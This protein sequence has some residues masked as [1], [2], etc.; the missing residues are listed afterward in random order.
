MLSRVSLLAVRRFSTKKPITPGWMQQAELDAA[1]A[2]KSKASVGTPGSQMLNKLEHEFQGER[3]AGAS[4]MEDKL[5]VLID[6]C[7]QN[8][9]DPKIY[10]ALRKRALA[11]R[12]EL[13]V[14]REAAGM[15][16]DSTINAASV[17]AAFPIPAAR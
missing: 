1:A 13:I 8:T 15:A 14:Q 6:K 10:D 11:A 16:K 9:S 2:S 4:R 3:V 5:K 12:Q 7:K 17:E